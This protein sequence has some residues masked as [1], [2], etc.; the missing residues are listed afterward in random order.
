M[1]TLLFECVFLSGFGLIA[2]LLLRKDAIPFLSGVYLCSAS[3]L[4]NKLLLYYVFSHTLCWVCNNKLC[5]CLYSFC[6][7][8]TFL[9]SNVGRS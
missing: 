5:T 6:L 1:A 8:E 9:L 2:L 4:I 3:D 7:L